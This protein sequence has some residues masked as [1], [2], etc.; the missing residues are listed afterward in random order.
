M[1]L[2]T[3]LAAG[4][5]LALAHRAAQAQADRD[6]RLPPEALKLLRAKG[7]KDAPIPGKRDQL[8][9]GDANQKKADQPNQN[10]AAGAKN[11]VN[12]K[13]AR[14]I[15][16][17]KLLIH[18]QG[19]QGGQ[20]KGQQGGEENG[21]QGEQGGQQNGQAGGQ[22]EQENG[23]AGEQGEQ[24]NGQAGAQGEQQNGQAGGQGENQGGEMDN[25]YVA[26]RLKSRTFVLA[27]T[28]NGQAL[29]L[30]IGTRQVSG[31]NHATHAEGLAIPNSPASL[32]GP[33]PPTLLSCGT[34][35]R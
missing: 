24:Q 30:L 23:Q 8:K 12:Q 20:K 33:R 6:L 22:G 9:A 28:D 10:R 1:G 26:P 3:V 18:K 5:T 16:P 4:L 13:K 21:Q 19:G 31:G 34:E 2:A 11:E 14:Q 25:D 7:N 27:D 17:G 29:L 15:N 35:R 32:A